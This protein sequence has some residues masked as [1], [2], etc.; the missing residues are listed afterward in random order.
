MIR[1]D[2]LKHKT[3]GVVGL[4]MSGEAVLDALMASGAQ[5]VAWDDHLPT[6][7]AISEGRRR[8]VVIEPPQQW[9]WDEVDLLVLSPGIPLTHPEPHPSVTLAKEHGV[10]IVGD[11]ELLYRACPDATYAV[12]TGTNG[13]STTTALIGHILKAAGKPVQVGGNIGE[14]ALALEPAGEGDMFVL[15]LSSYQLDL[16]RST[17][18][19]IAVLLNL[20]E[21]HIDR[22]GSFDNYV[23]AKKHIFDRQTKEQVAIIG[24][25]DTASE[26][27]CRE[28]IAQEHQT[29]LP[30]MTTQTSETGIY[31]KDN[32]LHNPFDNEQAAMAEMVTLQGQHNFQNA[33]AAYGVCHQLGLTHDKIVNG[34]K[35]FPGLAHR[36]QILG[37]WH[38]ITFVNDS[39]A[40]NADAAAQSLATFDHIHWIAGGVAKEGGIASLEQ[41]FPRI[42]HAYLIGQAQDAFA[43][44]LGGH[45]PHTLCDTLEAA[46]DKAVA[47]ALV[48]GE[49]DAVI[50]LAPACASF[51]QF[52]N[53][54]E[55]GEAFITLYETLTSSDNGA[56][57]HAV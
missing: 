15:E 54:E 40:T 25:D 20:S 24:I 56:S 27:V 46:F 57:A 39:K 38:G 45:V 10:E 18:F 2:F 41:Y 17:Q 31:V 44:T 6:R 43:A 1:L 5:I 28:M 14:P 48:S 35:T 33:A 42:A 26:A 29:V 32:I 30:V 21:D 47:G 4:A 11:I 55:R 51:D 34:M 23:A 37:E 53:F 3:V 8:E 12:I 16:V 19:D 7:I 9:H 22:H 13:K 50:L 49:E 52:K 36:M